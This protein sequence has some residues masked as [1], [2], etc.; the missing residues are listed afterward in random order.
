[1]GCLFDSIDGFDYHKCVYWQKDLCAEI[2]SI[3]G[4]AMCYSSIVI[5]DSLKAKNIKMQ[6][7]LEEIV[8]DVDLPASM[9][10]LKRKASQSMKD[11][12]LKYKNQ[13]LFLKENTES[14]CSIKELIFDLMTFSKLVYDYLKFEDT[15]TKDELEEIA[16]K[17]IERMK[18]QQNRKFI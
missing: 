12:K 3:N 4:D 15:I 14:V 1:M 5:S 11:T 17:N 10:Y 16:K 13:A 7:V 2:N 9:D 18:T 8:N 6:N